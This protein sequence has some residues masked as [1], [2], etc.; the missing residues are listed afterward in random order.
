MIEEIKLHTYIKDKA[1][2]ISKYVLFVLSKYA[3]KIGY[4]PVPAVVY[5]CILNVLNNGFKA[6]ISNSIKKH[7][8]SLI[9]NA[10]NATFNT[11]NHSQ[12][13]IAIVENIWIHNLT[14]ILS[15]ILVEK[16][17]AKREELF[18]LTI[19]LMYATLENASLVI[20]KE[21]L[22]HVNVVNRKEL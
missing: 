2:I 5:Q 18:A 13:I 1:A 11:M 16:F 14:V 19:V 12:N 6:S 8:L 21:Q 15:L 17:V 10:L 22:L 7:I 20:M 4:G 9:G 3:G